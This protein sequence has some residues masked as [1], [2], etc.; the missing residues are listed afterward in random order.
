MCSLPVRAEDKL[1]LRITKDSHEFVVQTPKGPFLIRRVKTACGEPKGFVQPLV[2]V[3]GVT[4]VNELDVLQ[5]LNDPG[6]MVIDMRDDDEPL[7]A[8]IPNSYHIPYNEMEDRLDVLGCKLLPGKAWDC[9]QAAKI[10][11]FCYGP[12]CVQ[13]P[14]GIARIVNLG[15][16]VAKIFYYR[17]GMLDWEGIGLTTVSGNRPLPLAR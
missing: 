6:A 15:Y 9:H 8:T 1:P 7:D 16:P 3:A 5:A 10:V 13:S 2:P 14:T 4:P 11:A 12:M 17:G